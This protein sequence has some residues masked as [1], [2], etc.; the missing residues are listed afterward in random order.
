[1]KVLGN[2]QKYGENSQLIKEFLVGSEAYDFLSPLKLLKRFETFIKLPGFFAK[3]PDFSTKSLVIS[4]SIARTDS[5]FKKLL[6]GF[7]ST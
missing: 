5:L 6:G 4:R 2:F 7:R 3:L 1:M